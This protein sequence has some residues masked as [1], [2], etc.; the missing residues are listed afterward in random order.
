MMYRVFRPSTFEKA[1]NFDALMLFCLYV[2]R[3]KKVSNPHT[4]AETLKF[5]CEFAPRAPTYEFRK[6]E[7]NLKGLLLQSKLCKNYLLEIITEA[8]GDVEKTGS[9]SQ[10]Y[11]KYHYRALITQVLKFIFKDK[12]YMEQ[13]VEVCMTK[14]DKFEKFTHF[15]I[16]DINDGFTSSISKLASIREY[17]EAKNNWESYTE[18]QKK[19][20][21]EQFKENSGIAKWG[22]NMARSA[23]GLCIT[24][25]EREE[26][27]KGFM[28]EVNLNSFVQGLNYTLD[29]LINRG[30]LSDIRD[31]K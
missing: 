12:H 26:C 5:I 10:Y 13:L 15:L 7:L 9:N 25:A 3:T 21:E 19:D 8:Y 14:A 22:M 18:E 23:L 11:E 6:E 27:R 20:F 30:K 24:I 31:S 1:L 4:R 2:I 16:S 28:S 17:E 29:S